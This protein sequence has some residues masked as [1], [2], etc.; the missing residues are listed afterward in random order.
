MNTLKSICLTIIRV[1]KQAWLFPQSVA[2]VLIVKRRQLVL[3]EH[4]I[5]RLDR[6]RNPS[7]YLGK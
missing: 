2:R 6:L 5:E 3:D 1:V 7:K 4:E